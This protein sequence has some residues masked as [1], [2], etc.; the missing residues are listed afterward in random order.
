MAL[1]DKSPPRAAA[2]RLGD[3]TAAAAAEEQRWAMTVV[4]LRQEVRRE[5]EEA[6]QRSGHADYPWVEV[7][8]PTSVLVHGTEPVHKTD[9]NARHSGNAACLLQSFAYLQCNAHFLV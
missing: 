8:G 3:S 6:T 2:P 4:Q 9:A 7:W 1:L 5:A